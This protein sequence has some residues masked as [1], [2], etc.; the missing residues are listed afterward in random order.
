MNRRELIAAAAAAAV[1]AAVPAVA[2]AATAKPMYRCVGD[3]AAYYFLDDLLLERWS[4]V[5]AC[6]AE[7]VAAGKKAFL[8]CS[9]E[10]ASFV[11]DRGNFS[12]VYVAQERDGRVERYDLSRRMTTDGFNPSYLTVVHP[13]VDREFHHSATRSMIGTFGDNWE[14]ASHYCPY[15]PTVGVFS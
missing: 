4:D 7:T 6:I 8:M 3:H 12:A 13:S 2:S 14:E 9:A 11:K 5:N 1:S 15:V 10:G